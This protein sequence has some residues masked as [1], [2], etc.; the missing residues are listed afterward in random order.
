MWVCTR[1]WHFSTLVVV[2]NGHAPTTSHRRD[3]LREAAPA[4]LRLAPD[5]THLYFEGGGQFADIWRR[6]GEKAASRLCR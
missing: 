5:V 1:G 6:A 2:C 4:L 3:T